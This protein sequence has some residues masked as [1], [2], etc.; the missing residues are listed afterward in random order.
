M[1]LKFL[2]KVMPEQIPESVFALVLRAQSREPLGRSIPSEKWV[3]S[4][5]QSRETVY[6][7]KNDRLNIDFSVERASFPE[8]QTMDPRIIRIAPLSCNERHK[9]A[10]E[11]LFFVLEG[12]GEVLVGEAWNPVSPGSLAFVPRWIMHQTLNTHSEQDLR[13][14]AITDFGFTSA[15][16][17][18]YDKRTRLSFGGPDAG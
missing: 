1:K 9:H 3:S 17:G 11:S 18:D 8:A 5:A 4:T 2:E 14:L 16:L 12:E 10:H 15:V 7:N 13:I 6:G